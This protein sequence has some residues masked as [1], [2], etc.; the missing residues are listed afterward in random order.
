MA[1]RHA[2]HGDVE[3]KRSVGGQP[4][5]AA[6]TVGDHGGRL[7]QLTVWPTGEAELVMGFESDLC[8]NEHHE[9]VSIEEVE[10]VLDRFSAWLDRAPP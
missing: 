2:D 9:L 10:S 1:R 7:A 4:K 6:W 8:V 3:F 5:A